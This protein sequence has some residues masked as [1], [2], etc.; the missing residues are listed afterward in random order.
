M[1][2]DLHWLLWLVLPMI[3]FLLPY[4]SRLGAEGADLYLYGENGWIEVSTVVFLLV[5]ILFGVIFL[6]LGKTSGRG[7]TRWW[8]ILMMLGCVYF[9]GEEISWGQHIFDWKT[10][11]SWLGF[12]DQGETN[13]HNTGALFDQIPRTFVSVAALIG[14]IVAPLYCAI[15]KRYPAS[16]S[17]HYWVWPTYVCLPAALFSLLVSWHEK[18]YRVL[19]VEVPAVLDVR[20]GEVK[21]SLLA[22]FIMLYVV[23]IWYRNRISA[24]GR[25]VLGI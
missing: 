15:T 20:A 4:I 7:W 5:A 12:N 17:L 25:L 8:M 11:Q 23:S 1:K 13:F 9:A 10:P 16:R 24:R 22:L 21:E 19:G 2:K 6:A 14:G 18:I 3:V